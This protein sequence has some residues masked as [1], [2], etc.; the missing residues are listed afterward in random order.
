MEFESEN[1]RFTP[2]SDDHGEFFF[3][4]ESDPEVLKYYRR[5]TSKTVEESKRNLA[6]YT[7]YTLKHPGYGAFTVLHKT[8]GEMIGLGVIIHLD[9]NPLNK[10]I[11]I[12]YRLP[13]ENWGK[14]YATEIAKAI[15]AH[16]FNHYSVTE[17]FATT[18][19]ENLGSQRVL[20]KAGFIYVGE[21]IYHGGESKL[22]KL[23]K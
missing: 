21:G 22:F 19:P 23:V 11:E 12:G 10:E 8:T 6:S 7:D 3:R 5:E 16:V 14:G 15:T 13:V 1:F 20:M 9:K 4:M 17:I 18:H 2:L